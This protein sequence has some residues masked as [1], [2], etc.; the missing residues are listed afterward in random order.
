MLNI[1][2]DEDKLITEIQSIGSFKVVQS[3]GRKDKPVVLQYPAAYVYWFRDTPVQQKP[4]PIH[5][6]KFHVLVYQQN[7]RDEDSAANDAYTLISSVYEKLVGLQI[8]NA[9]ESLDCTNIGLFDYQA[10]VISYLL[11]FSARFYVARRTGL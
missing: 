4:R 3:V 5:E 1:G 2:T 11:E 8:S 9:L 7:F 6:R 10:G